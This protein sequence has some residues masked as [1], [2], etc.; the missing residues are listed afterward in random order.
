MI[1][2]STAESGKTILL[3]RGNSPMEKN[4][5]PEVAAKQR[6]LPDLQN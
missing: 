2:R 3:R 5:F 4:S 6:Q 1:F